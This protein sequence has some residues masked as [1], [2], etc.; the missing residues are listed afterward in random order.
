MQRKQA[1]PACFLFLYSND[2]HHTA[3]LLL[4]ACNVDIRILKHFANVTVKKIVKL[5]YCNVLHVLAHLMLIT[6]TLHCC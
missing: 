6:Y 4:F 5:K 1:L 3:V 2:I